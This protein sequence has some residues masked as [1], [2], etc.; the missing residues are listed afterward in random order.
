VHQKG[1]DKKLF[2]FSLYYQGKTCYVGICMGMLS[3][4]ILDFTD[5]PFFLFLPNPDLSKTTGDFRIC[6]CLG[7][8]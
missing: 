8:F 4:V 3:M 2:V 7:H 1:I 6:S 5:N